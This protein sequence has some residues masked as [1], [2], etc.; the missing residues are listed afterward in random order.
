MDLS[1]VIRCADDSRVFRCIESIDEDVDI[2]VSTSS[3]PTFEKLLEEKG[4]R[5]CLSPRNNLSQTS[6]IGFDFALYDKVIITDSD[7]IFKSGCLN[8]LFSSLDEY[9]VAKA[10]L[11]FRQSSEIPF[12]NIVADARD[13]VN[14]KELA[15]TPGLAVRRGIIDEIGGF[16]FN[17]DVPFAVDAD[18]NYRV[19]KRKI[20]ICFLDDAV[21]FHD[22]ESVKHD[23][24][25]ARRI[26]K[27][28][29]I[30]SRSLE[31]KFG[32]NSSKD[33]KKFLKAVKVSDYSCIIREKGGL[34]L[35][36]QI[37]WDLNFYAGLYAE[38]IKRG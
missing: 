14:S 25:A 23:L 8:K 2:V 5:Y 26:G 9:P 13:Y 7:T 19:Q 38:R 34:V 35:I 29:S 20:P 36:Y 32:G 1:V 10:R 6:N 30:S 22:A 24:K 3:N 28:V 17:D 11:S 27:G 4:I 15:F 21:I 37:L 31:K 18:F 16:L 33:I 12:S